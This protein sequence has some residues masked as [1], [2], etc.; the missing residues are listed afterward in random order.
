MVGWILLSYGESWSKLHYEGSEM[1]LKAL[2]TAF[3]P[4]QLEP[5][6]FS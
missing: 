1:Q 5:S 3:F 6:S 4:H 2:E